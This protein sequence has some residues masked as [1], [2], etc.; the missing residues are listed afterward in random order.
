MRLF[1]GIREMTVS[2]RNI[3]KA[4]ARIA[5]EKMHSNRWEGNFALALELMHACPSP[6]EPAIANCFVP[7]LVF[8]S[9]L[10]RFLK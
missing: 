6:S 4:V 1:A 7:E 2:Q 9:I 10:W 5:N 8:L 3:A